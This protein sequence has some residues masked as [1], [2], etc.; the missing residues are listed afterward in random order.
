MCEKKSLYALALLRVS[1]GL[2]LLW[3]FFDKLLGL[4]F[5]TKQGMAWV[6]GVSPTSYYLA[7][8][9]H[10]PLLSLWQALVGNALVDWTFMLG[11]LGI[12][13]ALTL[14]FMIR[15]ASVMGIVLFALMYLTNLPPANNPALDQH[16][17]Y[18][19]AL[20]VIMVSCKEKRISVVNLFNKTTTGIKTT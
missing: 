20:I 13:L 19:L 4:G 12:G 5:A 6:N 2:M 14:G 10:G 11:L 18:I 1:I 3:A 9:A 17:V 8:V 15:T 7:K 16:V